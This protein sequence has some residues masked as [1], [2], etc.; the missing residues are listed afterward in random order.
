MIAVID[1]HNVDEY[2]GLADEMFR[3]RA[4][5]FGERL[6]W[7]VK[8]VD[9]KERDRFDDENPL[10][11]IHTDDCKR[12]LGS[13]R[14]LPTTGPT[15]LSE[16]FSDSLPDASQLSSPDI[17]ECTRFC[18]DGS[19][20]TKEERERITRTSGALIAAL[21][22]IGLSAGIK[23]YIGNVDAAMMRIYR[24]VGCDVHVIG[25]TDKY[26]RRVYLGLFPVSAATLRRV[27]SRLRGMDEVLSWAPRSWQPSDREPPSPG[28]EP[29]AA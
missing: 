3:L 5:E 15:V 20:A 6:K 10:Y 22:E 7:N 4:R 16:A 2:R 19:I 25:H 14:I 28:R 26:G 9:G 1:Q 18:V 13:L 17:W 27:K 12:V 29:R 21:G 24:R 8:I 11:V 23:S